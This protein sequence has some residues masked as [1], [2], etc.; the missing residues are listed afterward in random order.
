MDK[1][2][3]GL[4]TNHTLLAELNAAAAQKPTQTDI[5]E[6]RVSYVFGFVKSDSVTREHVRKVID[7]GVTVGATA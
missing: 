1:K 6:Q 4:S 7:G 2:F 3:L 5:A